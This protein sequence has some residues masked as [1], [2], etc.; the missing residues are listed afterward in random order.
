MTTKEVGERVKSLREERKLKKNELANI[1]GISPT[2]I[3]DIEA[4]RKCPTVEYLSFICD[5]LNV[6][7]SQFFSEE[8]LPIK[9]QLSLDALSPAQKKLFDDFLKSLD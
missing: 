9:K 3:N 6:S 1:A 7:L 8:Q 2:Y 4:G 5:A